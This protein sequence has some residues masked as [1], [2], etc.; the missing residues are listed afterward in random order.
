[1]PNLRTQSGNKLRAVVED[2]RGEGGGGKV[3]IVIR[4]CCGLAVGLKA[5]YIGDEKDG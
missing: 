4:E 2:N 1:M 5:R 3:N